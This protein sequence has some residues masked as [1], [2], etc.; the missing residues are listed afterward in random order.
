MLEM[1]PFLL[2]DFSGM[3]FQVLSV[4]TLFSRKS[5]SA[6]ANVCPSVCLSVTKTPQRLRMMSICH[7]AY[8]LMFYLISQFSQI[9]DLILISKIFS[10]ESDSRIANVLGGCGYVKSRVWLY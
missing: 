10:R 6:I 2:D 1:I 8:I 9:S 5:D 3:D 4:P 7:Y